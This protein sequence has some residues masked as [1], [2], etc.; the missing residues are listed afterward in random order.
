MALDH[1][2]QRRMAEDKSVDRRVNTI[3]AAENKLEGMCYF[4]PYTFSSPGRF[5]NDRR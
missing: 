1:L 4:D 2:Q 3:L 5:F